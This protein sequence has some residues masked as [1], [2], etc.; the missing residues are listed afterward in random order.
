MS[1][2]I[3][4]IWIVLVLVACG[5]AQ[6]GLTQQNALITDNLS[7]NSNWLEHVGKYVAEDATYPVGKYT[8]TLSLDRTDVFHDKCA[9]YS[10]NYKRCLE[11]EKEFF[12][13]QMYVG[14]VVKE[15]NFI[16]KNASA[17]ILFTPEGTL[18]QIYGDEISFS[19]SGELLI[20][21]FWGNQF[22]NGSDANMIHQE[23]RFRFTEGKI[24]GK[25]R[26]FDE[27]GEKVIY[28]LESPFLPVQE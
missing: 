14:Y 20:K 24:F 4:S 21:N 22:S 18:K 3:F 1:R 17:T 16:S 12:E 2:V 15:N 5:P 9:K 23:D 19:K 7:T 13:I 8:K 26:I 11:W 10:P 6:T 27:R 25:E 28:E